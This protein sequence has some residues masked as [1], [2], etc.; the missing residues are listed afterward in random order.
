MR[1]LIIVGAGVVVLGLS[2]IISN[3]LKDSKE[4]PVQKVTKVEKT[5]F[6]KE[7]I[8]GDV[9]INIIANGLKIK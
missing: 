8:N 4:L 7:V 9:A 5:V 3:I 6:V 1:K 2:F